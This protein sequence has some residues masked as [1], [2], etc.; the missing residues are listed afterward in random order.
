MMNAKGIDGTMR[1]DG[2]MLYIHKKQFFVSRG[3]K[4]IPLSSITAIQWKEPALTSGYIQ[5]VLKGSGESKGGVFDA[6]KD[7]NAILFN[8]SRGQVL[9]IR[10]AINREL[11]E[12]S[13]MGSSAAAPQPVATDPIGELVRWAELRDKGVISQDEYDAKKRQLL[14]L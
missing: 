14:G 9:A 2:D 8:K 10:D 1:L 6:T 11:A 7:E 13:R 3:E 4:A 5:V 12:R